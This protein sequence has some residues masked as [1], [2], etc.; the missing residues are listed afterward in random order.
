M[1]GGARKSAK[2]QKR[3]GKGHGGRPSRG[4]APGMRPSSPGRIFSQPCTD[5]RAPLLRARGRCTGP[6]HPSD[7]RRDPPP[8]P[9]PGPLQSAPRGK[10]GFLPPASVVVFPGPFPRA[11]VGVDVGGGGSRNAAQLGDAPASPSTPQHP[12]L[13]SPLTMAPPHFPESFRLRTPVT[14][15]DIPTTPSPSI[16]QHPPASPSTP[17]HPPASPS[18]P[19]HPPA[20]P[21]IPQHPP[22]GGCSIIPLSRGEQ[23]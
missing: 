15:V 7:A 19:Q 23:G 22:A 5:A 13:L 21:S 1:V 8:P 16:P 12:R 20:S 11:R 2:V 3:A 14:P 17:Q 9:V 10:R 18:I 4:A 6:P